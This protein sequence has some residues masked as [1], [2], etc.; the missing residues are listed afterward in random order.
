MGSVRQA[1][2]WAGPVNPGAVPIRARGT[3]GICLKAAS[4]RPS[5][6]RRIGRLLFGCCCP[7]GAELLVC[8]GIATTK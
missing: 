5:R 1:I 4:F 2:A 3:D 7:L 6:A 8:S